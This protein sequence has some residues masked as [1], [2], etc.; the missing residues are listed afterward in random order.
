LVDV[1]IVGGGI[2][3]CLVARELLARS[4]DVSIVLLDR[5]MV[6]AG[7]TRRSAG[8]HFPRGGTE[9]VRRMSRY[10][11]SY[12]E[13]LSL[14]HPQ[15]PIYPAGLSVVASQSTQDRLHE[16]YLDQAKLARIDDV[17]LPEFL[18]PPGSGVWSAEGGHYADVHG[19]T[20]AIATQLRAAISIRE[21]VRVCDLQPERDHVAL[22][23]G[24]GQRLTAT[25]V[26]LAP[27]PWVADP[28]WQALLASLRIRIK[29]VV[30]VHL[31]QPVAGPDQAVV[32][33]DEDAFLLSLRYRG[34]WLFSYTCPQWGVDPDDLVDGVSP[35][36][37]ADATGLL[38]RYAPSL[39]TRCTGGRVFCDAYSGTGEPLVRV[40]DE[41]RRIVFAGAANGSG[42]RLAP[43][44]AVEAVDLLTIE[45]RS[46]S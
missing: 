27:G 13:R 19:L 5:D 24:N 1:A 37:L 28:A 39:A 16:T 41:D 43:A 31:D 14:N 38:N 44:I 3:G 7:A 42:Y 46:H 4:P 9:R 26:V 29:K 12:Y 36:D 10:S 25:Q 23:L 8:L 32:F 45:A 30:A 34:H 21:A 35:G 40:L 18:L 33:H 22:E 6:A 20:Q 2:L 15:L 11:Q 17:P